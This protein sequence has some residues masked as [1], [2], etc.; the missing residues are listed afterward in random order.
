MVTTSP[1]GVP[2]RVL[3]SGK[4]K[5]DVPRLGIEDQPRPSHLYSFWFR[6]SSLSITL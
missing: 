3:A 2:P 6:L 5:C 1:S 4:S